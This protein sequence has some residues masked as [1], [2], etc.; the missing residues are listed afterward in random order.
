VGC[1]I[2]R[3]VASFQALNHSLG[4]DLS[5][6]KKYYELREPIKHDENGCMPTLGASKGAHEI[7]E[8]LIHRRS[9]G[10]RIM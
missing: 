1:S 9:R 10:L 4:G 7:N 5:N 8:N 3:K 2:N 6:R